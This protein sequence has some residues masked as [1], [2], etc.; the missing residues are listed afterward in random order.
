MRT[1]RM[2][3]VALFA[4]AAALFQLLHS[5][6]GIPTGFGMVVDLAG[7]PVLLAFFIFG[8]EEAVGVLVLLSLIITLVS[9]ETW[10]G[11]SM[12]FAGTLPMVLTPALWLLAAKKKNDLGRIGA[13]AV[14]LI[15]V[16][17]SLFLLA[18]LIN[19]SMKPEKG[20][21]LY[22]IPEIRAGGSVFVEGASVS[23]GD[24][25]GGLS[26]IVGLA[27]ASLFILRLWGRYG[28]G[29]DKASLRDPATIAAITILAIV[30]RGVSMVLANYYYAGPIFWGMSPEQVM[31]IAPWYLIFGFNAIQAAV[32]LGF[33]WAIAFKFRF[34][35]YY[36]SS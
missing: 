20:D 13:M 3:A 19:T 6:I 29:V 33:A 24:L 16:S 2:V 36:G 18:G 5:V 26:P 28:K 32:E 22:S 17:L 34:A 9:P 7:L 11:A 10:L 25:I 31:A 35:D 1:Y 8:F 27:I 23:I 12:K 21:E 15:V 14:M 30:V 4:A